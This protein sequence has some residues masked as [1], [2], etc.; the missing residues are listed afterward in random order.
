[1]H[2]ALAEA[3][4]P[5]RRDRGHLGIGHNLRP[6]QDRGSMEFARHRAHPA[7]W[8]IPVAGTATDHVVQ[9][10]AVCGERGIDVRCEGADERV[11][12]NDPAN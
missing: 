5:V 10:A 11:G 2:D 6:G 1:M 4:L 8:N 12:E 7:Y 3:D 9:K